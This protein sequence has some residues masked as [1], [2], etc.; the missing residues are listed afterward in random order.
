MIPIIYLYKYKSQNN[1]S[2][3][4]FYNSRTK[5]LETATVSYVDNNCCPSSYEMKQEA[6]HKYPEYFL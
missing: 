5:R 3:V 2:Y 6:L 4:R 1:T